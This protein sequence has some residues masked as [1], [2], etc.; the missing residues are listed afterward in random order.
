MTKVEVDEVF[1]LVGYVGAKVSADDTVPR[2]VVLLVE[3]FFDVRGNIFFDVVLF[4][5]LRGDVD[6]VLLHVLGHVRILDDGFSRV[7]HF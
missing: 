7:R 6:G 5:G 3:L 1:G 4:D 2:W